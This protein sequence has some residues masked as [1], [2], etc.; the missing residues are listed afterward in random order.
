MGTKR[1]QPAPTDRPKPEPSPPPP[2]PRTASERLRDREWDRVSRLAN[3]L[4]ALVEHASQIPE[5]AIIDLN[6]TFGRL[7]R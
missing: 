3:Q 1:H 6:L 7:P 4:A 5:D 2:P